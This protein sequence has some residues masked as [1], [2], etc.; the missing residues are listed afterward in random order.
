MTHFVLQKQTPTVEVNNLIETCKSSNMLTGKRLRDAHTQLGKLIAPHIG[1]EAERSKLTIIVLLR[2]GLCFA[3]GI[4]DQI[5]EMGFCVPIVFL[6]EDYIHESDMHYIHGRNVLIVDAVINS[7]KSV[8][9]LTKQLTSATNIYFATAVIPE[10]SLELLKD[11]PLYCA[12]TSKH[13]YVGAKV[14]K[15]SE[16]KGPDTG[17][18]LFNTLTL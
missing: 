14:Q 8:L 2:A 13:K 10:D 7:G 11:Y 1:T 12:R 5:E 4:A 3:L 17:D 9:G 18:R 6:N 16:G 15:I